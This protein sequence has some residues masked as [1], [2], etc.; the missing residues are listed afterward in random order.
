MEVL[1]LGLVEGLGFRAG[2]LEGLVRLGLSRF[3]EPLT[4]SEELLRELDGPREPDWERVES[5]TDRASNSDRPS[6]RLLS[7]RP[8]ASSLNPTSP[9][10]A[11][12]LEV[13]LEVGFE[14]VFV[15]AFG[16]NLDLVVDL[17]FGVD[18][19]LIPVRDFLAS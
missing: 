14:G 11:D 10:P 1:L 3:A 12:D 4:L 13:R 6:A 19:I 2:E 8:G 15:G 17:G 9:G 18:S 5:M 16:S 7:D